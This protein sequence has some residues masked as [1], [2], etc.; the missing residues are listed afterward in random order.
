V[1]GRALPDSCLPPVRPFSHLIRLHLRFALWCDVNRYKS[2]AVVSA[3][4]VN[5]DRKP[6]EDL[7][8]VDTTSSYR[9][10]QVAGDLRR[11]HSTILRGRQGGPKVTFGPP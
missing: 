2:L 9:R 6:H 11:W 10:R 8:N 5:A 7:V 4:A 3:D 1:G